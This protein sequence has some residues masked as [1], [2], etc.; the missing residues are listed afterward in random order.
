MNEVNTAFAR[1]KDNN[2][3]ALEAVVIALITAVARNGDKVKI[4]GEMNDIV[5]ARLPNED[6]KGALTTAQEIISVARSKL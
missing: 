4:L 1:G 5:K 2:D 3:V 6:Q